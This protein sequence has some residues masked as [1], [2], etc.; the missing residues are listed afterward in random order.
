MNC[1]KGGVR[2][3]VRLIGADLKTMARTLKK[4]DGNWWK[5]M[6]RA[7]LNWN[8]Y[9]QTCDRY[10]TSPRK[11]FDDKASLLGREKPYMSSYGNLLGMLLAFT[12]RAPSSLEEGH[13][14]DCYMTRQPRNNRQ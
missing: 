5:M 10:S 9:H 6:Q 1:Q 4:R 2:T 14:Y 12:S 7:L 13:I 3:Q 11:W 8:I